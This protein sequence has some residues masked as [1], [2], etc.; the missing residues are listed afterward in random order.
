MKKK[1]LMTLFLSAAMVATMVPQDVKAASVNA[2]EELDLTQAEKIDLTALTKTM[3]ESLAEKEEKLNHAQFEEDEMVTVIVSVEE[4]SLLEEFN[5]SAE[6]DFPTFLSENQ[7]QRDAIQRQVEAVAEE[8]TGDCASYGENQQAEVLYTYDTVYSGFSVKVPYKELKKI[9]EMSGVKKA[10]IAEEY[11]AP[12]IQESKD[13]QIETNMI[14]SREMIGTGSVQGENELDYT[15][16][17]MAV[18]ILDT[19]LDYNH[20]AFSAEG[21]TDGKYSAADIQNFIDT[22]ELACEKDYAEKGSLKAVEA[23]ADSEDNV[24][25]SAKVP[26]TYDYN[27]H[28]SIAIPVHSENHGT[29]V[30]GTV[31][32]NSAKIKG[33][34]PD[35]Q[36]MSMKVFND[37]GK[38]SDAVLIAALQDAVNLNVDVI[39]MSL[40]S[41]AGFSTE[42]NAEMQNVYDSVKDA[43]INLDVSAGNSYTGAYST[44]DYNLARAENVDNGIVGSPSTLEASLS[45]ASMENTFTNYSLVLKNAAGEPFGYIDGAD[46]EKTFAKKMEYKTYDF[47]DCGTGTAEAFEGKD[48]TGKIALIKR[49]DCTFTEKVKNAANANAVA[50]VIYNNTTGTISMSVEDYVIPAVSITKVDG[51]R[52]LELGKDGEGKIV[53]DGSTQNLQSATAMQMSGFSS[54]GTTPSLQIKPEITAPGGNIYSSY[55]T[56]E[57][58]DQVYGLMSG[59]SMAAPHAS[60]ASALV[61]QYVKQK[62]PTLGSVDAENLVNSLMMST[63]VPAADVKNYKS[64]EDPMVY[65]AVREQGAGLINVYD[66]ITTKAYLEVEGCVRPKAELGYNVQGEYSYTV[67]VKNISNDTLSYTLDTAVQGEIAESYGKHT[68][69][70][71]VE[72]SIKDAT[73]VTYT[74]ADGSQIKGN[75]ITVAPN[76]E[77]SVKVTLKL[78]LNN[79]K[80]KAYQKAYTNGFFVEGFTFARSNDQGVDLSAPFLGF[81][82]NWGDESTL[83]ANGYSDEENYLGGCTVNNPDAKS[84]LNYIYGG[85]VLERALTDKTSYSADKIMMSTKSK[86]GLTARLM[87]QTYLLR[88]VS[89]L[90]Y[91]LTDSNGKE[92]VA[93]TENNVCKSYYYSNKSV[94]LP[95]EEFVEAPFI[96]DGKDAKGKDLA[97]GSYK[98]TIT[99]TPTA[100]VKNPEQDVKAQAD[101]ISYDIVLDNTA[102]V[103]DQTHT[104]VYQ[105]DNELYLSLAGTDE[106]AVAGFEVC[107]YNKTEKKEV[108]LAAQIVKD[109]KEAGKLYDLGSVADFKKAG[110]STDKVTVNLYDYAMNVATKNVAIEP[111]ANAEVANVSLTSAKNTAVGTMS[112][113]WKKAKGVDGY[114]VYRKDS[115]TN[116]YKRVEILLGNDATSYTDQTGIKLGTTYTYKVRGFKTVSA[117]GKDNTSY[118]EFSKAKSVM[119]MI[120]G[121]TKLASVKNVKD[122]SMKLTWK[123]LS[124][125]TGYDVYRSTTKNGRFSKVASVKTASY[126]DKK[127]VTVG[128]TYYYKV[129]AYVENKKDRVAGEF[130]NVKV[131]TAKYLVT[132]DLKEV[133]RVSATKVRVSWTQVSGATGYEVYRSTSKNT[134]FKKVKVATSAKNVSFTDKVE[135]NKI[136]YYRVKAVSGRTTSTFSNVLAASAK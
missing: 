41:S 13:S 116:K 98:L 110:L 93:K 122:G 133:K 135:K 40:G 21:F 127:G 35:A 115:T 113:S 86:L 52:L 82:G 69:A 134:G 72:E 20:E 90:N 107:A 84:M 92:V 3:E 66:A 96:F 44:N 65:F 120:P 106:T 28:E 70:T 43:G 101:S 88:G 117:N 81:C 128:K 4:K 85:N 2:G 16:K 27:D 46:Y 23:T 48:L 109:G 67:K 50:A 56:T 76:G 118:G 83:D 94:V 75:K 126:A 131:A 9:R 61:K 99:A 29:H 39:N 19:G 71:Q 36:V 108:T 136:Y 79:E 80:I 105:R 33:V 24:Y 111:E 58:G 102:P 7:G 62:F 57:D 77:T 32:G 112:L 95:A 55:Y 119:S 121:A 15:G 25:K 73:T 91:S 18:A 103:I 12:E 51:E 6:T 114:E 100:S 124:G 11:D 1:K 78:D 104:F 130:S 53:F 129:K 30:A 89:E 47:V 97:D 5:E 45:T 125:A 123:A 42:S 49:G 17:G 8:I 10:F 34:A 37:K 14:S 60:G 132:P 54:W 26:F 63:A 22:K 64:E 68:Y 74:A 87:P 38:T 59:T 31:A